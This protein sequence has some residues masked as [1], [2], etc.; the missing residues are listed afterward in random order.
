[1]LKLPRH[2]ETIYYNVKYTTTWVNLINDIIFFNFNY[3]TFFFYLTHVISIVVGLILLA[4][5]NYMDDL[6]SDKIFATIY[7]R[8]GVSALGLLFGF[9]YSLYL[10]FTQA[11]FFPIS[12]L[13]TYV[14]FVIFALGTLEI[15][16]SNKNI[17]IFPNL[18]ISVAIP[19]TFT[20]LNFGFL[21]FSF[22]FKN[23]NT[24]L[25]YNPITLVLDFHSGFCS[26]VCFQQIRMSFLIVIFSIIIHHTI[27]YTIHLI[28]CSAEPRVI[29][30]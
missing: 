2:T 30:Y 9:S 16:S 22:L 21:F 10:A 13:L 27:Y 25:H 23:V 11:I 28:A 12:V 6:N 8:K 26:H 7:S 4:I 20:P 3:G 5:F 29:E 1:M 19:F 24:Y 18:M 15:N 17:L 14:V